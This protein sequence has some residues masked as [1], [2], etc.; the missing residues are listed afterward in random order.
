MT[1]NTKETGRIEISFGALYQLALK[2]NAFAIWKHAE[3][4][5][6]FEKKNNY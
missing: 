1:N 3:N 2:D 5:I 4:T 6:N